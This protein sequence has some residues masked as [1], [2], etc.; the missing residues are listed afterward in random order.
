MTDTAGCLLKTFS[1]WI[2]SKFRSSIEVWG[3][4]VFRKG[5]LSFKKWTHLI[6]VIHVGPVP[7]LSFMGMKRHMAGFFTNMTWGNMYEDAFRKIFFPKQKKKNTGKKNRP[8]FLPLDQLC[9][10]DVM[11]GATV[12]IL[13]LWGESQE[14]DN[15]NSSSRIRTFDKVTL[16]QPG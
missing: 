2:E 1:L 3:S 12:A 9:L 4:I 13:K 10:H 7:F 8:S 11:L 5:R 6:S 14:N 15:Q 16:A